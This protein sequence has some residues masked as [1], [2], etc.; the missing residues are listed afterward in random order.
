VAKAQDSSPEA[1]LSRAH[2][3]LE[4]L[5][6]GDAFGERFFINSDLAISLIEQKSVPAPPWIFTDDTLMAISIVEN[7]EKHARIQQD[8]LAYSFARNYD[9]MRGYGP[10]MHRLLAEI[11]R[12]PD[13]WRDEA[14]A[15]FDGQ[16]SFG[17]GSAMRVAPLGAYFADDVDSIAEQAALSA[18]TTHC[19]SEALAGATAVALAAAAA[20]RFRQAGQLPTHIEFLEW[21]A[22]R[23]PVSAVRRGIELA[24]TLPAVVPVDRAVRELGN[25]KIISC[26]DTV[27]FALWS[28]ACHLQSYEEALW[29]TVR[30]LGDRD[31]TCAIVGGIVVMYS[32]VESIPSAWLHAREPIP[33]HLLKHYTPIT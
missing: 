16:G 26:P 6:C 17:N 25:G 15:L 32:G 3:S 19:H 30:G 31:T 20:W 13:C 2:Q 9:S 28:A 12:R 18:Q 21:I 24:A 1:R 29:A 4:G 23:M 8:D 14:Q 33:M 5:S 11:R 10:A 22:Q 7:L 27:P